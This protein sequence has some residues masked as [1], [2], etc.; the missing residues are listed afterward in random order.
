M[1]DYEN[2]LL[3]SY[4]GKPVP[5]MTREELIAFIGQLDYVIALIRAGELK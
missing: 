5:E 1:N 2:G 4:L 3:C